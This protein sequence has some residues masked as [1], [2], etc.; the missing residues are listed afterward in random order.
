MHV[1]FSSLVFSAG[2]LPE[3]RVRLGPIPKGT[4]LKRLRQGRNHWV[5]PR[6]TYKR[7][8]DDMKHWAAWRLQQTKDKVFNNNHLA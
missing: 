3:L 8:G 4:A 1:F 6:P 5:I 2:Y 7:V